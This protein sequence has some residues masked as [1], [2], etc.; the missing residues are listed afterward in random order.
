MQIRWVFYKMQKTQENYS[1]K[2]TSTKLAV[3]VIVCSCSGG[4]KTE[5]E[6]TRSTLRFVYDE[7]TC[8]FLGGKLNGMVQGHEDVCK[9]LYFTYYICYALVIGLGVQVVDNK[10][11]G[12]HWEV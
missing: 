9:S 6:Q 12:K 1:V 7:D 8:R 3:V 4:T 10:T 5:K 2:D 11:K